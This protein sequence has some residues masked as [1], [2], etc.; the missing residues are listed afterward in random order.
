MIHYDIRFFEDEFTI[1]GLGVDCLESAG[2]EDKK[3]AESEKVMLQ[4]SSLGSG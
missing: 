1:W 2:L 3:A 4:F